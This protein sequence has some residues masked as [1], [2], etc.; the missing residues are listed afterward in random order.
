ML[1]FF[2]SVLTPNTFWVDLKKLDFDAKTG[3]V[4]KLDLGKYQRNTFS[5]EVSAD[6]E[7]GQAV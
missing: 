2:E 5:G 6:F 1:Y 3:K 4:M 7:T